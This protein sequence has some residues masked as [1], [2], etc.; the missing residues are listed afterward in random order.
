MDNQQ[1]LTV[2]HMKV[3][4]M[5]CTSLD[6]KRFR[7]RMDT[8]VHMAESLCCSPETIT[9]LLIAIPQY[10]IKSFKKETFSRKNCDQY[11]NHHLRVKPS[12]HKWSLSLDAKQAHWQL[13]FMTS[14]STHRKEGCRIGS[15][16]EEK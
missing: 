13:S 1:G 12:F 11:T 2:Q 7:G 8:C 15:D 3:Y 9:T 6:E 5:L 4:M 14:H 16:I 10:K